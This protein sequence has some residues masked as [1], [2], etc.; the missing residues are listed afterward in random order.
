LSAVGYRLFGFLL[1]VLV[2]SSIALTRTQSSF[3]SR[4]P[5]SPEDLADS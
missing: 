2:T 4:H 3:A 5:F 1:S